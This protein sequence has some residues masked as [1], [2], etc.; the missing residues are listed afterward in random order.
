MRKGRPGGGAQ[1]CVESLA[2]A[3]ALRVQPH[4]SCSSSGP[5]NKRN[6]SKDAHRDSHRADRR[7]LGWGRPVCSPDSPASAEPAAGSSG[8]RLVEF[9]G[10]QQGSCA[11][12]PQAVGGTAAHY[13]CGRGQRPGGLPGSTGYACPV[14]CSKLPSS[15]PVGGEARREQPGAPG[16]EAGRLGSEPSRRRC[17]LPGQP[18]WKVAPLTPFYC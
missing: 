13:A 2:I 6:K 9:Y 11:A 4:R 1:R 18:A 10:S 3:P 7:A 8:G 14:R 17:P 5:Q 15:R 12:T 16:K